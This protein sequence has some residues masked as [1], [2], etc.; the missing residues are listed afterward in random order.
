MSGLV[1]VVNPNSTERVTR[2]IDAAVDPLRMAGGP[3]I[4]CVT[5]AAGPPGI[6]SQHDADSVV[7]PLCEYLRS[8][9][10]EADAFVVACYSDPGLHA[11]R[12]AVDVPVLGIAECGMLAALTRGERF[13]VLSILDRA[14]PRHL[15]YL[16]SLGLWQRFAADLAIGLGIAELGDDQRVMERM[17]AVGERLRDEHQA[18]VVVMGC[19]GMRAFAAR[20]RRRWACP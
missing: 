16:R 20:W 17:T 19:A 4:E 5:L 2:G 9:A 14:V 3:A 6:E 18:D 11:A 12:E 7:M 8:R 15:R 1:V 13:G 10:A